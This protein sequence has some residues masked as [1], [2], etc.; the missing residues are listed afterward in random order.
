M[1]GIISVLTRA[2]LAGS[3]M[4]ICQEKMT[5]WVRNYS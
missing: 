2:K 4:F 3:V 5:G 1:F